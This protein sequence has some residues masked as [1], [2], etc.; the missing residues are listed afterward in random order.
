MFSTLRTVCVGDFFNAKEKHRLTSMF[1]KSKSIVTEGSFIQSFS[2][3][4]V[5]VLEGEKLEELGTVI[6]ENVPTCLES[7]EGWVLK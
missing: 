6:I 5:H 1:P 3:S 7:I 4:K 2:C